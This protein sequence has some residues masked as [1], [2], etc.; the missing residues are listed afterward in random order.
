M[1]QPRRA[2]SSLGVI[3]AS[4]VSPTTNELALLGPY[5]FL[6]KA[7]A[8]ARQRGDFR[9][10]QRDGRRDAGRPTALSTSRAGRWS[11]D[12]AAAAAGLCAV[13]A[14]M[15]LKSASVKAGLRSTSAQMAIT[16]ST[17]RRQRREFDGRVLRRRRPCR[18][19]RRACRARRRSAGRA[20]GRALVQHVGGEAREAVLDGRGVRRIAGVE[21]HRDAHLRHVMPLDQIDLHAAGQRRGLVG[22]GRWRPRSSPVAAS[23]NWSTGAP[24]R[25][26]IAERQHASACSEPRVSHLRAAACTVAG[27]AAS[28]RLIESF[29]PPASPAIISHWASCADLVDV[30]RARDHARHGLDDVLVDLRLR[31][32]GLR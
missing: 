5:Q 7:A 30:P 3:S 26:R 8:S 19:S 20:R 22:R 23:S 11:W 14:W 12:R 28:R 25:R 4:V 9:R 32:A 6:W 31:R 18:H 27:V 15:R 21:Q 2:A 10:H 1:A 17:R 24:E 13:C 29:Q 16:W